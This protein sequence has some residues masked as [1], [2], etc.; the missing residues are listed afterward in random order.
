MPRKR[1][2]KKCSRNGRAYS[3]NFD[4][5]MREMKEMDQKKAI[6]PQ[7]VSEGKEKS[8][9]AISHMKDVLSAGKIKSAIKVGAEVFS[10]IVPFIEDP[11]WWSGIRAAFAVG[12][13]AIERVEFWSDDYF[14]GDEW[15]IP[16]TRDFN[17]LVLRAISQYPY[18]T[19]KASDETVVIRS[20]DMDGIKVAYPYNVNMKTVSSVYVETLKLDEAKQKIKMLLWDMYKDTNLVM[21]QNKRAQHSDVESTVVLEPDDAFVSMPSQRAAE[22]ASYLKKCIDANVS[23]SVMLYGP[24]GTGK[25]TMARTVVDT[26]GM[27]SFRIRV[28]DVASLESSTLFEAINIFEPDAIILD[29]FDRA[30]SQAQLLETLEFFQ[31]HVKLVIATVNDRNSLD[32]AILRPGRFDELIFVKN[33]EKDVVIA[34]LGPDHSDAYETVKNWPIAF[35]QEYV[36]RRKFM[37][38]EEA[39]ESTVELAMRVKRLEK[40]DDENE[41]ER[42]AKVVGKKIESKRPKLQ[43]V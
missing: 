32:E 21:R 35:I 7:E 4:Q 26:L 10:A 19:I 11:N 38:K 17:T 14:A 9:S 1:H 5:F 43:D 34:V 2:S 6:T 42:M 30:N 3:M 27:R 36:K 24:P 33:M 18:E 37:S 40:Y 15:S 23:R 39:E 41:V 16:Y 12:K 25:S 28:E 13:V 29:D 8:K 20:I 31:R 22:Y